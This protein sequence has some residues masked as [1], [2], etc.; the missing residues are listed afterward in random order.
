MTSARAAAPYL[1]I[2]NSGELM[3]LILTN[4]GQDRCL[5]LFGIAS[6][7]WQLARY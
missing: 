7:S 4:N 6:L 1:I 3:R 2:G 5:H